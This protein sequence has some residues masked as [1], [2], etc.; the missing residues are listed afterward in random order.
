MLPLAP[1]HLS[2]QSQPKIF[3]D[4]VYAKFLAFDH[5]FEKTGRQTYFEKH[6][7]QELKTQENPF[8]HD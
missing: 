5:A 3:L 4:T 1:L 2:L 7:M 8:F 6:G